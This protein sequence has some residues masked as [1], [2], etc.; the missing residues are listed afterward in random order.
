MQARFPLS[1]SDGGS[2]GYFEFPEI[3]SISVKVDGQSRSDAPRDAAAVRAQRPM[4]PNATRSRGRSS[5]WPS[6][7]RSDVS[8]EVTYTVEGYGY[9]P[10]AIFEYVLETGAGW[11]GTIGSADI[12]VAAAL[13]GQRA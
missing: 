6:R 2:D 1:F 7:R 11:N 8:V 10:Q 13:R 5:M 9:Y 4:A 12:I 3:P